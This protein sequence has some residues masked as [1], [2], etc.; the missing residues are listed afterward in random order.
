MYY[1]SYRYSAQLGQKNVTLATTTSITTS[2]TLDYD[3]ESPKYS[4]VVSKGDN[5]SATL[6]QIAPC[7]YSDFRLW[8]LAPLIG[9]GST[10]FLGELVR[11]CLRDNSRSTKFN[12]LA[13]CF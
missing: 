4:H 13:C 6:I 9:Q 5:K 12:M 1:I 8:H 11:R 7:N 10:V 3:A 2:D